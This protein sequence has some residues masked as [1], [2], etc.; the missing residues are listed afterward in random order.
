MPT[1]TRNGSGIA[2]VSV[3]VPTLNEDKNIGGLIEKINAIATQDLVIEVVIVDDGSHDETVQIV[4]EYI[5]ILTSQTFSMNI[6]ERK[7]V[8]GLSSAILYGIKQARYDHVIIM[9]A[10]HS[11]PPEAIVTMADLLQE[12]YDLVIGSRY[13][14]DGK[15]TNWPLRRW[16]VSK[17]AT[18]IA[19]TGLNIQQQD[20]L[21]GYFALRKNILDHIEL[22][23]LGYKILMEIL[24]KVPSIRIKEMPIEFQDRSAGKSKMDY[25]TISDFVVSVWMLYRYGKKIKDKNPSKRFLSKSARFFTVGALGLA[26]NMLLSLFLVE[27]LSLWIVYANG[28]GILVSMTNNFILNKIW[29]FENRCFVIRYV[30]GQYAKFVG[31]SAMGALLQIF[32]AQ[33]LN[34][35]YGISN[36]ES[37]VMAVLIAAMGN[38]LLNKKFTFGEKIWS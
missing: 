6:Y 14:K 19:R 35:Y 37:V 28:V 7:T 32:M 10:D 17:A 34:E 4:R 8:R 27:S 30:L 31:F 13:V 23:A 22:N 11:H 5:Q 15:I 12:K 18:W 24:A 25:K 16:L 9:D 20:P 33:H 26:I 38:F 2:Q 29:T 21:S 36:L 1:R 3:I